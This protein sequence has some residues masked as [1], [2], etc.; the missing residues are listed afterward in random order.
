MK[1]LLYEKEQLEYAMKQLKE[2]HVEKIE[3]MKKSE[4]CLA[5]KERADCCENESRSAKESEDEVRRQVVLLD[6]KCDDLNASVE[7]TKISLVAKNE[8]LVIHKKLQ[9][10][11]IQNDSL[12]NKVDE[13]NRHIENLQL[14]QVKLNYEKNSN[15]EISQ[16]LRNEI[17][18]LNNR[19]KD[20]LAEYEKN[21]VA[22]QTLLD[23]SNDTISSLEINIETSRKDFETKISEREKEE[24][25]RRQNLMREVRN[26]KE[27]L[28]KFE[29][30]RQI[31][32]TTIKKL[33]ST[34]NEKTEQ[35][36]MYERESEN[37][38]ISLRILQDSNEMVRLQNDQMRA[39][40]ES[41]CRALTNDEKRIIELD[42]EIESYAR[43]FTELEC[44][45]RTIEKEKEELVVAKE[46][47]TG[48]IHNANSQINMLKS[49][50]ESLHRKAIK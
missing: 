27:G 26:L 45:K 9:D 25:E 17:Q 19:R 35:L 46:S 48:D 7:E 21:S 43:G 4:E 37:A 36:E 30:Q 13:L 22:L 6:K 34:V 15:E 10:S 8:C 14:E 1:E 2:E 29:N 24:E 5:E 11:E 38:M 32:S 12:S 42:K 44:S 31:F 28:N 50:V 20:D 3:G 39:E 41:A 49:K 47:L 18:D 23:S 33:E 40:K 16:K